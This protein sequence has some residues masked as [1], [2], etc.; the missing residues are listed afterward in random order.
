MEI[1]KDRT[2][3]SYINNYSL[4]CKDNLKKFIIKNPLNL[5]VQGLSRISELVNN[6]R[7]ETSAY[8]TDEETLKL[9]YDSL[10]DFEK[11]SITILEPSV[12]VANFLEIL[13]KK[14]SHLD[15][16]KIDVIDLDS[17]SIELCKLLNEYRDIPDNID[18]NYIVYD[19]LLD[20]VIGTYDLVI[21][22]THFSKLNKDM[23]VDFYRNIFND[24]VSKNLS[25][26]FLQ[27]A[28]NEAKNVVMILPK[29]FLSNS[30]F[31][32]ARDIANKYE[33][34]RIID[35]GEKGFKGVLIETIAL[36][37]NT[38]KERSKTV[39]YSVT[40]NITNVQ[41]QKKLTDNNFP[42]WLLYRNQFFE[43]IASKMNM[44]VFKVYRDRSITNAKLNKESG[45][46][47]LKSRNIERNGTKILDIENY[48]SYI[49]EDTLKNLW[50]N[51]YRYRT[52]AFLSP[53]MTYYPRIIR[54]PDDCV[55]NGS[56]AILENI[57]NVEIKQEH[58]DFIN[59]S[60]FEEFYKIARNH[61]TRSLNID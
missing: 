57:K 23:P 5:S 3:K 42:N 28:L 54:K 52:Y 59:S 34:E 41:P 21:G 24:N 38:Q 58:L 26:F 61:S 37:I 31:R 18:I 13:I 27:K 56:V 7:S 10:P 36:F 15:S 47:V 43:D 48:D 49:E 2:L 53:N 6:R 14:Y 55:V 35:F 32:L 30:D 51:K 11:S 50:V 25:S 39:S 1:I 17:E 12:G 33:I 20:N 16:V 45:I 46:R 8:Y 22:N 29:Y 40:K 9:I 44:G 4:H 60:D 19:Y